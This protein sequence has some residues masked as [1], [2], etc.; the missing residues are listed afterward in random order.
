MKVSELPYKRYTIE[1]GRE[2]FERFKAAASAA[3][4]ADDMLA[5]RDIWLKCYNDAQTAQ[6]LSYCRFTLDTA[7]EFYNGEV[8]YYDQTNPEFDKLCSE[9]AD[10]MLSS[11][12]RAELE[13][14]L[15]SQ[16]FR[17]LECRKKAFDPCIAELAKEENGIVTEY[18]HLMAAMEFEFGGEKMPLS[19]LRGNLENADRS[20]RKAAA[21][22]MGKGLAAHKA[23][24]DDIFDRLVHIRDREA[25]AMG[26][27]DFVELG[28][29][30][31][32]RTD[33]TP[34]M[35]DAF[36]ANVRNDLVPAVA[37]LKAG[38]ASE[39]GIDRVMYY[40][41][42][43]YYSGG[44]PVPPD[45]KDEIFRLAREMYDDMDPEVGAFMRSMQENEA[46]DV[47]SRNNK[48][49]G[50]YCI[51][52]NNFKQP[53]ILAN[54]NGTSDDI[55]VITHEFGHALA[56]S[57]MFRFGDPELD[58][59]GMETAECHSMS[60][61]FLAWKYMDKFFGSDSSGYKRKHL[62][63][64]LSFIPYGVI[65]D[66]FQHIVYRNPDMTPE[67][68]DKAYLELE[69]K[70]RPYIS[71][72]GIP[73]LEDGTRWQYQMHIY[74]SPFYYIDYCLAQ[75]VALGFLIKS[76]ADYDDALK[77]YLAFAKKGGTMSFG[78][79]VRGAGLPTPFD[80][81]ALREI[82]DKSLELAKSL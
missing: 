4:S 15:G 50:G 8:D 81:G 10:I 62:L 57:F 75:T 78:D 77:S 47:E 67:E 58:V 6:T 70:Y 52:F 73:Y 55:D 30:R 5:A 80:D 9:Y 2:D 36:R 23:E 65:V 71:F 63:S 1:Q 46:F 14:R 28:Y 19:K 76:Q 34:E 41:D 79:L 54:F 59:G 51:A 26:Y 72:D 40:D 3:K 29:Y 60:M 74:E 7:D 13:K 44:M 53:F 20:V 16:L 39:L 35:I 48:W 66:E 21:E 61:E 68:R 24:L 32:G 33:Y 56:G 45:S 49:G 31:M 64:A 69:R 27:K 22:A 42:G 18:T 37:E 38:V 11:P 12:Y 82:S 17:K 43:I 25:K